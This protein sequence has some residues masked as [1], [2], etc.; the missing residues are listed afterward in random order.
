MYIRLDKREKII[1]MRINWLR[2]DDV[3]SVYF[4]NQ[5]IFLLGKI[6]S[7]VSPPRGAPRALMGGSSSR[8]KG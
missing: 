5:R 4:V 7:T 6:S 2:M 3:S 8:V 1:S